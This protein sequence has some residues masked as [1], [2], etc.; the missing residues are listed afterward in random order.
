MKKNKKLSPFEEKLNDL[1]AKLSHISFV[2]KIFFVE[3]ML[4]TLQNVLYN[5]NF[6]VT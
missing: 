1:F 2:E 5:I 3:F 4:E 6:T